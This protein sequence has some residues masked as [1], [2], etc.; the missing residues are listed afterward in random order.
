MRLGKQDLRFHWTTI[1][2]A[3]SA[4]DFLELERTAPNGSKL[5]F[6][7]T[8]DEACAL[9]AFLADSLSPS[10]PPTAA[11]AIKAWR[12]RFGLREQARAKAGT[13]AAVE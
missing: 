13:A 5:R 2:A 1:R 10:E 11:K 3:G 6:V 8:R 12:R 9:R 7:L 4:A